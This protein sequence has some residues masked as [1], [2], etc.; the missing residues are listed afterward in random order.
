VYPLWKLPDI[1]IA[2]D[3]IFTI[4]SFPVSNTLLATWITIV[5]LVVLFFLA[6]RNQKMIPSGLQNLVE[7]AVELL[8]GLVESV[9][10]KTKGK[11][12]FPL[13][14]T[15]FIF[16]LFANLL[17]VIPG[18]DT[19]GTISTS[20]ARSHAIWGFLLFGQ[21]SNNIIPWIR[22]A[23]SDLNLT[24]SLALVS[25]ITTQ[26]FGFYW[27][28]W[29]EHLSKYFNFKGPVDFFV[30]I[31]EIVTEAARIL[32]FSFRLFGNVF[33]GSAV[34]TVFAFLLPFFADV[35]FIPLEL[36]VA[37]IQAFIFAILTLVF[38]QIATSSHEPHAESE[39]EAL[40][41]YR[42]EEARKEEE[43]AATGPTR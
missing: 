26:I 1:R 20:A 2:P 21:Y 37:F 34:L 40:E 8:L 29:K 41:E 4:G 39:H 30:G 15:F 10:G 5:I 36:F 35:I 9:A 3:T 11:K 19:I 6:T 18:V 32:S 12:F 13:V 33:A 43:L 17:D 24:L 38:M 14:A 16:I 31:L 27:L 42:H 28:G 23:T 22:P 25:V 7:W